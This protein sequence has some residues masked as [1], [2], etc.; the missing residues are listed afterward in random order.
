MAEDSESI[1]E[2]FKNIIEDSVSMQNYLPTDGD[3]LK[4]LHR[5]LVL[6]DAS[7]L[8]VKHPDILAY[9]KDKN[10]NFK[11]QNPQDI[12][13]A[14]VYGIRI[15]N[16]TCDEIQI[17]CR[18]AFPITHSGGLS[19]PPIKQNNISTLIQEYELAL[20]ENINFFCRQ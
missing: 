11:F 1:I 20:Q 13:I 8:E 9:L 7:P 12:R 19:R 4:N 3:N 16:M 2:T 18:K 15:C 17:K 10:T 5:C 6:E 14:V